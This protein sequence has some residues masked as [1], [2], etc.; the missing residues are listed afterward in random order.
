MV[1][2]INSIWAGVVGSLGVPDFIYNIITTVL[3][4]GA[5]MVI[6]FIVNRLIFPEGERKE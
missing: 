3:T 4:G 1:N 2:S 5:A 6:F